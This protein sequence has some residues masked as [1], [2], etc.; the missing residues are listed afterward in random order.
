MSHPLAFHKTKF[1]C[2]LCT[3]AV[4]QLHNENVTRR[5]RI[6]AIEREKHSDK[7]APLN[8]RSNEFNEHFRL[9]RWDDN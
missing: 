7:V 3:P 9:L 5:V 8:L 4:T 1:P 2:L 6:D